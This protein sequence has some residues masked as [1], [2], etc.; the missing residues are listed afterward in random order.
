M[1]GSSQAL[2]RSRQPGSCASS[3]RAWFDGL[4][5]TLRFSD[6]PLNVGLAIADIRGALA[7]G[8]V[9]AGF[10]LSILVLLRRRAVLAGVL[11]VAGLMLDLTLANA[12]HVVTVPQSAF[13]QP[14]RALELIREAE[15]ANPSVGPYRIQRVGRWWPARWAEKGN[16]ATLKRSH[17][18]SGDSL[19][20]N[21]QMPL[22]TRMTFY[23]DTIE[24]MDYGLFFLPW[25]LTPEPSTLQSHGL[26][27]EQKVW[28]YPRRGFDLWNTRY[29]I[30]PGRLVWDSFPR[31]YALVPTA[32]HV[33]LPGY[34]LVRRTGRPGA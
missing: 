8:A 2:S 12:Y 10:A 20:P 11:A 7:H 23:H 1:P 17:A 30:V 19:R 26:K 34:W 25:A 31:G 21:Y 27:P 13:E 9:V 18:G 6:E 14:P 28:Y 33:Y 32:F 16:A 3:L 4:A 24:P 22:G 5:A 15:K 29:F